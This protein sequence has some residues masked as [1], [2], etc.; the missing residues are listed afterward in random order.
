MFCAPVLAAGILQFLS[1]IT[2]RESI[3][4]RTF[5]VHAFDSL[6]SKRVASLQLAEGGGL[7]KFGIRNFHQ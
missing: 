3:T 7:A 2:P 5:P 6:T 4:S 1:F